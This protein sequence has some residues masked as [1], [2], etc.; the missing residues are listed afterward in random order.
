VNDRNLATVLERLCGVLRTEIRRTGAEQGLLPVHVETL[1]YLARCNRY[2]DTPQAVAEYLGSTK[3]TVS[4][5]LKVLETKKMLV[6]RT[7]GADRRVVRLELTP[8][9]RRAANALEVPAALGSALASGSVD[10][11]R[12]EEDL[13]GL[14]RDVQ[15]SADRVS[16][17]VCFSCRYHLREGAGFRCG[18]TGE[19][20]EPFERDQICRDH[21]EPD[22]RQTEKSD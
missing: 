1:L 14:L 16:F 18:L 7:D 20:L 22:E 8:V 19:P 2:S 4:Q 5:S 9:G 21:E 17:G 3:G 13:R 15:R 6:K 12:L 11:S 10:A